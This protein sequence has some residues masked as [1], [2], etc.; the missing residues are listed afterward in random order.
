MRSC[1]AKRS[2]TPLKMYRQGSVL[3]ATCKLAG[4]GPDVLIETLVSISVYKNNLGRSRYTGEEEEEN[5]YVRVA[6]CKYNV[7]STEYKG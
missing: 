7:N 6:V 1:L 4:V 2:N 3:S 5:T